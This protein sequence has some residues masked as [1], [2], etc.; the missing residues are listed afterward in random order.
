M[1][2]V[3]FVFASAVILAM[4]IPAVAQYVPSP[5]GVPVAPRGSFGV[6]DP[7]AVNRECARGFS[8]ETCLRRENAI[9]SGAPSVTDSTKNYLGEC[10]VGSSE[11]TCRRRGQ[12]YNP[13]GQN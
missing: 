6:T 11:E 1:K 12:K 5:P 4:I 8:A 2:K 13:P 10:A 9:E 7:N 3:L